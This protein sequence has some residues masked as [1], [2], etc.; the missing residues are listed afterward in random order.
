MPNLQLTEMVLAYAA[1]ATWSKHKCYTGNRT[2]ILFIV[3]DTDNLIIAEWFKF[4]RFLSDTLPEFLDEV[5][6]DIMQ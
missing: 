2:V 4:L 5:P 3:G 6:L 1:V